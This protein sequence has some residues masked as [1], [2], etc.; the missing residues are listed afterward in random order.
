MDS[1]ARIAALEA[2]LAASEAR[3][4]QL[5]NA[6]HRIG[7]TPAPMVPWVQPQYVPQTPIYPWQSPI[8]C[9]VDHSGPVKI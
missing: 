4:A 3:I 6:I 2:R 5:E 1:E 7:Q 8:W 9:A